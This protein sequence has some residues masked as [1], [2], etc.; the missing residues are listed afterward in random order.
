MADELPL[1]PELPLFVLLE[2]LLS[3]V[4]PLFDEPEPVLMTKCTVLPGS[5]VVP[6]VGVWLMTQPCDTEL[7]D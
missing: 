2:L 5:S 3:V 1:V 7:L 6:D 4:V